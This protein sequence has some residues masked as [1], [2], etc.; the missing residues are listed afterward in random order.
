[1]RVMRIMTVCIMKER[2]S[3]VVIHSDPGEEWETTPLCDLGVSTHD[4]VLTKMV[5]RCYEGLSC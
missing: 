2:I 3:M 5:T 1:M 4:T